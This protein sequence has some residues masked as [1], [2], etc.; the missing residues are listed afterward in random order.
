[1]QVEATGT[2]FVNH[3]HVIGQ[4]ELFL[5]EQQETGRGEPLRRLG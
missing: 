5:H 1:M 4:G 2:G 3:E